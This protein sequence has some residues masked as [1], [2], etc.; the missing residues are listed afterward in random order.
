MTLIGEVLGFERLSVKLAL[1]M[2]TSPS[3]T[4]MSLIETAGV[5]SSAIVKTAEVGAVMRPPTLALNVML[6]VSSGSSM[7]SL[8]IG[9]LKVRLVVP[10]GKFR[11]TVVSV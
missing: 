7:L 1:D 5:S 10:S 4:E 11:V 6:T 2:P 8:T 9:I 3:A